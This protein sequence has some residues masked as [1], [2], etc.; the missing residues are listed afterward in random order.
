MYTSSVLGRVQESFKVTYRENKK[1][2]WSHKQL[3]LI[4]LKSEVTCWV[5]FTWILVFEEFNLRVSSGSCWI[6]SGIQ[7]VSEKKKM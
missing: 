1:M 2:R 5:S 7:V 3:V 6:G 4:I